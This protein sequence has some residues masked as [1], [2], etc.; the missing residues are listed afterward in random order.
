MGSFF[1]HSRKAS[2]ASI[3]PLAAV[4]GVVLVGVLLTFSYYY[5]SGYMASSTKTIHISGSYESA[6]TANMVITN[7]G[8]EPISLTPCT[9]VGDTV[10]CGDLTIVKTSGEGQLELETEQDF[11]EPGEAAIIRD[12][13]A[14]G[15]TS[16]SIISPSVAVSTTVDVPAE[17]A[18]CT[19]TNC[20]ELD[21]Y[22][23]FWDDDCDGIL[24]CGNCTEGY[25]CIDGDCIIETEPCTPS[26]C[27]QLGKECGFWDDDC[28]GILDCGNCTEGYECQNGSCIEEQPQN[29]QYIDSCQTLDQKHTTYY[30]TR[31]LSGAEVTPNCMHIKKRNVTLDCQGHSIINHNLKSSIIYAYYAASPTIRNCHVEA[32]LGTGSLD[33]Y[34]SHG[35]EME[36]VKN[37]L[38]ENNTVKHAG[39][40]ILVIWDNNTIRNNVIENTIKGLRLF[41]ANNNIVE[42]NLVKHDTRAQGWGFEIWRGVG[43]RL[44]NN[45][46]Y[47]NDYGILLAYADNTVIRCGESK[48]NNVK[49]IYAY[50][51]S[52]NVTLMGVDYGTKYSSLDSDFVETPYNCTNIDCTWVFD[53]CV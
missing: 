43:N 17:P 30:L 53:A 12:L 49:D 2:K 23:G 45:K 15:P 8:T 52:N 39:S 48:N 42:N 20:T 24:D 34:K 9:G 21:K 29:V 14:S 50:R 3:G 37:A 35:I 4:V 22:C 27:S 36:Y 16:Y 13:G 44:V 46:A 51:G 7:T 31:D 40:G 47:G 6:G 28:D 41:R 26:N 32:Y 19:P 18:S 38:I 5:L 25:D 33:Y 10:K 1:P 11:I